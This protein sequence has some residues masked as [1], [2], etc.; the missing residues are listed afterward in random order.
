MSPT[1]VVYGIPIVNYKYEVRGSIKPFRF[2]LK[3]NLI[4]LLNDVIGKVPVEGGNYH[5][6]LFIKS[7]V[8][9]DFCFYTK[10]FYILL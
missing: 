7:I 3:S 10:G 4:F 6:L 5:F 2:D 8:G 1:I 9:S